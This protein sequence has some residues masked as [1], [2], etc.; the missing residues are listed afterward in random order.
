MSIASKIKILATLLISGIV[1]VSAIL[2][3]PSM[4]LT[5]ASSVV[6]NDEFRVA[7]SADDSS[8]TPA[9]SAADANSLYVPSEND[10]TDA[11]DSKSEEELLPGNVVTKIESNDRAAKSSASVFARLGGVDPEP[12]RADV[13]A[14]TFEILNMS[15][16]ERAALAKSLWETIDGFMAEE[17]SSSYY[18][19]ATTYDLREIEST[20]IALGRFS[21]EA[22]VLG[23]SRVRQERCR[24][25]DLASTILAKMII[26]SSVCRETFLQGLPSIGAEQ[27]AAFLC[28]FWTFIPSLKY[29]D[30]EPVFD[31]IGTDRGSEFR[32]QAIAFLGGFKSDASRCIERLQP[33]LDDDDSRVRGFAISTICKFGAPAIS[34]LP[35]LLR[36]RVDPTRIFPGDEYVKRD[37][38]NLAGLPEAFDVVLAEFDR[39]IIEKAEQWW[40]LQNIEREFI[41]GVLIDHFRRD[42]STISSMTRYIFHPEQK[43]R[44][45][46]LSL[47]KAT[48]RGAQQASSTLLTLLETG[49]DE[50][51]GAVLWLVYSAGI[52]DP[53]FAAKIANELGS[54]NYSLARAARWAIVQFGEASSCAWEAL[55]ASL[56]RGD[57]GGDARRAVGGLA[58]Y[59]KP[60]IE[61]YLTHSD[62]NVRLGAIESL[63][64][65]IHCP[66][67]IERLMRQFSFLDDESKIRL[68]YAQGLSVHRYDYRP[69][70]V[71]LKK[72]VI[73]LGASDANADVR[74]E[75]LRCVQYQSSEDEEFSLGV[76]RKLIIDPDKD[77]GRKAI[78]IL[79]EYT[80]VPAGFDALVTDLLK[81]P[82][83]DVRL[84]A[85]RYLE[86]HG[87]SMDLVRECVLGAVRDSSG[88]DRVHA[89]N[90]IR[91]H[92]FDIETAVPAMKL[93]LND[94]HEDV[95]LEALRNT[96]AIDSMKDPE[97]RQILER[98]SLS[99]NAG[100]SALATF[101]LS[102]F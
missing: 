72:F 96:D 15:A 99:R 13:E 19:V 1:G 80:A 23:F 90:S 50:D 71:E 2:V 89:V 47:L 79:Y 55:F 95:V 28:N 38:K 14:M 81:S 62:E 25:P 58:E 44:L 22:L 82:D 20:L 45:T 100:I 48:G 11:D 93:A 32:C 49:T 33:L 7:D 34:L 69:G 65:S 56:G 3:A 51:K 91:R 57:P 30:Y 74:L 8:E 10:F 31:L 4:I 87:I 94:A 17:R 43:V 83:I 37:I 35:R 88:E 66:E 53:S 101:Y 92:S 70:F 76:V 16:D 42:P 29:D 63:R 52:N 59:I 36:I 24:V 84:E 26:G 27:L 6:F 9:E 78:K 39:L 68:L 97:T 21:R 75:S 86:Y 46:A 77:I 60:H 64:D 61:T 18:F 85:A 73:E 67:A 41:P 54:E 5:P 102:G 12:P 98:L 40:R